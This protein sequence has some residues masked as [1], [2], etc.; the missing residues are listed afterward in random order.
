MFDWIKKIISKGIW[1]SLAILVVAFAAGP[2][3]LISMELMVLVEFLGA[4][5]FVL[6]YVSGLKL[7]LA[8]AYNSF[9]KPVLFPIYKKLQQLDPYFF[10]PSYNNVKKFPS[11]LCHSIPGFMLL[12]VGS[13]CISQESG[14][15]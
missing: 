8:K 9:F 1:Y 5:T 2:E 3:I 11:L 10:V 4:S 14:L 12:M 13:L 15:V 7:F 6:M